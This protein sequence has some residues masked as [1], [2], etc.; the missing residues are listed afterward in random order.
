MGD[1]LNYE[2]M[3]EKPYQEQEV[4]RALE[5][6]NSHLE[7]AE[8]ILWTASTTAHPQELA[9]RAEQVNYPTLLTHG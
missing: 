7:E 8:N 3:S 4:L 5:V 2:S 1:W 6:A 9:V